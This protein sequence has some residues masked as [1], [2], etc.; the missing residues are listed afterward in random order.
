MRVGIFFAIL[1]VIFAR[2]LY[3]KDCNRGRLP[4]NGDWVSYVIYSN[5][6]KMEIKLSIVGEEMEG[7]KK[8]VW[9]EMVARSKEL[10][11]IIKR[12]VIGDPL[13]PDKT[14]RQI[15]KIINKSRPDYAPAIELPVAEQ[16]KGNETLN[17][18]PC[19]D[20][21][22][23]K[24]QYRFKGQKLEAYIIKSENPKRSLIIY[25]KEIPF[26]GVIKTETDN[27]R[28]ELADLGRN[29]SSEILEEPIKLFN[30]EAI[31]NRE[32]KE[33]PTPPTD[34]QK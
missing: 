20:R 14:L 25:S 1:F 10:D 4:E 8:A 28:I 32:P 12:L 27:V 13:E 24:I 11:F 34:L 6:E 17:S 16:P 19:I 26:F 7:D 31:K 29:A 33:P 3:S 30:T 21:M 9:F 15:V 18:F 23:E 22:G 5:K 2:P